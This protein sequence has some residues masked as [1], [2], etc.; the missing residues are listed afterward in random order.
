MGHISKLLL[1]AK[2]TDAP[3]VLKSQTSVG[4][5]DEGSIEAI[6]KYALN[7]NGEFRKRF[8][9]KDLPIL[10]DNL[11]QLIKLSQKDDW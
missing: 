7:A 11:S 10:E 1:F 5:F 2:D 3:N 8:K 9:S 6:E 4:V